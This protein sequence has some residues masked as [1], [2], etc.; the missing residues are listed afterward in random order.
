[1]SISGGPAFFTAV[2]TGLYVDFA[3]VTSAVPDEAVDELS[4][5]SLE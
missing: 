3:G 5:S 1:M 2:V 4:D